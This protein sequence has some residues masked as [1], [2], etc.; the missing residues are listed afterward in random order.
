MQRMIDSNR[1][2]LGVFVDSPYAILNVIDHIDRL[3]TEMI[4]RRRLSKLFDVK[5]GTEK[6][7]RKHQNC[8]KNLV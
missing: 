3:R 8:V 5:K 7:N 6:Y 1:M 2:L 4:I